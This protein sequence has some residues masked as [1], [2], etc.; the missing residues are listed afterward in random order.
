MNEQQRVTVSVKMS[1]AIWK[2]AKVFAAQREIT[3]SQLVEHSLLREMRGKESK[4][5]E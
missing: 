2:Q 5:G 4:P 1:P 3:L